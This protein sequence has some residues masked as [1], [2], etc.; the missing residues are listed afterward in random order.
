MPSMGSSGVSLFP[1]TEPGPRGRLAQGSWPCQEDV[2]RLVPRVPAGSASVGSVV[3][4]PCP[5]HA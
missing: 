2:D 3:S 1:G 5:L 4:L